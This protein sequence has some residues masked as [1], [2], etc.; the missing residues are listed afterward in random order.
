MS[1]LTKIIDDFAESIISSS[2]TTGHIIKNI[3]TIAKE[4]KG[5]IDLVVKMNERLNQHEQILLNLIEDQDK[6]EKI[7]GFEFTSTQKSNQKPN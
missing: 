5:L 1:K 4:T 6:K 3:Q 7:S 2:Q